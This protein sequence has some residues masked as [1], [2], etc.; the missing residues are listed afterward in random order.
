MMCAGLMGQPSYRAVLFDG[1][2]DVP[3]IPLIQS[4]I[5]DAWKAGFDHIASEQ[6]GRLY[7]TDK[8]IGKDIYARIYYQGDIV[9]FKFYILY[10]IIS[11][12]IC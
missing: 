11:Y 5:E 7:G 3:D 8:W 4:S 1:R 2:C 9:V 6:M 10:Y 12:H